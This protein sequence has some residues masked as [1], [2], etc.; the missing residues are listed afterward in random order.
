[1]RLVKRRWLQ[2]LAVTGGLFGSSAM[3]ADVRT[4]I[5]FDGSVG[6]HPGGLILP[7]AGSNYDIPESRGAVS[8]EAGGANLFHSFDRFSIGTGDTVNFATGGA[9]NILARVTGGAE[10]AIDGRINAGANLFLVNRAG[11]VFHEHASIDVSGSFFATT[12]DYIRLG[13]D[14]RF[15]PTLAPADRILSAADPSAFGFLTPNPKA[16]QVNG[17]KLGDPSVKTLGLIGGDVAITGEAN[18]QAQDVQIVSVRST[19]EAALQMPNATN[20]LT[21]P[22][23]NAESFSAH[24]AISVTGPTLDPQLTKPAAMIQGQRV[25]IRGGT[26]AMKNATV[27]TSTSGPGDGVKVDLNGSFEMTERSNIAST[28]FGDLAHA[29]AVEVTADS[30]V[31]GRLSQI[32]TQTGPHGAGGDV[33]LSVRGPVR[34]AD[35]GTISSDSFSSIRGGDLAVSAGSVSLE[36]MGRVVSR[37]HDVGKAGDIFLNAL[38][39]LSLEGASKVSIVPPDDLVVAAIGGESINVAAG[40]ISVS[41][42]GAGFFYQDTSPNGVG[43]TINLKSRG[44]LSIENGGLVAA[45]T[46]SRNG[47]SVKIRAADVLISGADSAETGITAKSAG[48]PGTLG[49]EIK[50]DVGGAVRVLHGGVISTDAFGA[51]TGGNI[52]ITATDAIV[53]GRGG[54]VAEF[55]ETPR[56][57]TARNR[58]NSSTQLSGP[59]GNVKLTLRGALEIRDAGELI[60]DTNGFGAGGSIDVAAH[61]LRVSTAGVI[62]A[63]TRATTNA[64]PGGSVRLNLAGLAQVATDGLIVA[65]T[66]GSG[67]GGS[68]GLAAH[69][70]NISSGGTISAR[71]EAD[72]NGGRGGSVA[73]NLESRL[74]VNAGGLISASTLGD[75]AGGT[76]T[77]RANDVSVN[78]TE[79]GISAVSGGLRDPATGSGGDVLLATDSLQIANDGQVTANTFGAGTGG[80]VTVSAQTL[81]ITDRDRVTLAGISAQTLSTGSGGA[82]GQVKIDAGGLQLHGA[83]A[84]ITTQ[85]S[86]RGHAGQIQIAAGSLSMSDGSAIQS[87]STGAGRAGSLTIGVDG[88]IT[89]Q[90]G[91]SLSVASAQSDSG[92]IRVRSGSNISLTD[93]SITAE[94]ATNGGSIDLR[95]RDL[96]LLT[97]SQITAAAGVNGGNIFIDPVFVVLDQSLISAKAILGRGGNIRIISDFFIASPDSSVTATSQLGIDGTVKIDAL[98]NDLTGSLVEL[99]STLLNAE[100]LLQE[101]CTVKVD[102]FSSFI[103]E[104]RGGLPPLPGEALPSL[105]IVR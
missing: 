11:I 103:S 56:G 39:R 59:S 32:L 81:Q 83:G 76:I 78:G 58:S 52:D 4:E 89:L 44:L 50:L 8:R 98:N 31:V 88:A 23:I 104:G 99:P 49:G 90:S 60:V 51:G 53:T 17:S 26:L 34:I 101:L 36:N 2:F 91:S 92:D 42:K 70:L 87:S 27:A 1:M 14:G 75:G 61:D 67:A 55:T 80:S 24:G 19:G 96:L 74:L 71:T 25:V 73:L 13:N 33:R 45:E 3:S 84:A 66:S 68:I 38:G 40:E 35:E 41:G 9:R 93:S 28:N 21:R 16:I 6:V 29:P 72:K 86:G 64:G 82:G 94:A 12:A 95:A 47:A 62:A 65:D 18:V 46:V 79:A 5:K 48:G 54:A 100:S 10:S 37:S 7:G 43:G 15:G 85:S 20:G 105:T 69:D 30:A 63:R 57:I 77:I 97:N 102:H 22:S